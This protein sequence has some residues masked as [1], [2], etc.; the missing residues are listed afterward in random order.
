MGR[1]ERGWGLGCLEGREDSRDKSSPCSL[2]Y[3]DCIHLI[4]LH[5]CRKPKEL[6]ACAQKG[7]GKNEEEGV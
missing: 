1:R 7:G 4:L 6:K 2:R 3:A 5:T